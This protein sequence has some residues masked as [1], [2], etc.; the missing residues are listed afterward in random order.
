MQLLTFQKKNLGPV[1][2]LTNIAS[3]ALTSFKIKFDQPSTY[4]SKQG[5]VVYSQCFNLANYLIHE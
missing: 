1:H 5:P 3:H 4:V 2:L